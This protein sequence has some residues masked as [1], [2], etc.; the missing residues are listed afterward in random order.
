[1]KNIDIRLLAELSE[2]EWD[3]GNTQKVSAR[4][5]ME[6]A[7]SA[8]M[9]EP[10]IFFDELHSGK[11]PRWFLMNQIGKKPL[12]LVFTVRKDKIRIIS[13]RYMHKREVSK[14]AKKI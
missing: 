9:G 11:E 5:T 2:F 10:L 3:E 8:F 1:M 4:M 14:Y 13:A 7:E 12:A 6:E